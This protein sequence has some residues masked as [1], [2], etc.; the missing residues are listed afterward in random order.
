MP[1]PIEYLPQPPSAPQNPSQQSFIAKKDIGGLDFTVEFNDSVLSTKGWSNPRYSGSLIMTQKLNEFTQG[2][3]TYGKSIGIQKYTTNIYLGSAIVNL[4]DTNDPTILR[5]PSSSYVT[6][7]SAITVNSRD[8]DV[9]FFQ[10]DGN[11]SGS[12]IGF[13]R[14][15]FEDFP[16]GEDISIRL[17]DD[18]VPN[19]LKDKYNVFFNAGRLQRTLTLSNDG[20]G[21]QITFTGNGMR[22]AQTA[23]AY[24]ASAT[25]SSQNYAVTSHFNYPDSRPGNFTSGSA[26]SPIT[27]IGV[28]DNFF[29]NINSSSL[30]RYFVTVGT[31][32][33]FSFL[34]RSKDFENR[35]GYYTYEIQKKHPTLSRVLIFSRKFGFS[36]DDVDGKITT[37]KQG[38][39]ISK[40]NDSVPCLLLELDSENQL[41]SGIGEAPFIVIPHNLHPFIKDNITFFLRRAG[42]RT[43]RFGI[44]GGGPRTGPTLDTKNQK[45]I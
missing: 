4:N 39:K 35:R 30:D 14:T 45:L 32:S 8:L 33:P 12:K 7:R 29:D 22:Y 25:L 36:S 1:D 2:D 5:F 19:F 3:I 10:F 13:Y 28:L 6:I 31:D 27:T 37:N 34:E 11:D 43:N 21:G 26:G 20:D 16:E 17:L 18:T 41:P 9:N 44:L 38:Y 42:I 23:A 15:F 24:T 40:L